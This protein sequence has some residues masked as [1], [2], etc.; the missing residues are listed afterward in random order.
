M[1]AAGLAA[2]ATADPGPDGSLVMIGGNLKENEQILRTIVK[3]AKAADG[4][5][6]SPTIAIITAAAS[7]ARTP[8]QGRNPKK[9]NAQANGLYYSG[10]FEALGADTYA[11]PI[12][13]A[14]DFK[15]DPYVPGNAESRRV[16][17]KVRAADGVFFGGGDQ[18][19]YVRTLMKDC[20]PSDAPD[21]AYEACGD[22]RVL[23]AVRDVLARGGVVAGVSAGTTIQQGPDMVTGGESYQGWQNGAEPG[24][25]ADPAELAYLPAGGFNFFTAGLVDS[26]F[27]TWG[28]QARM[29]R[30]AL[31][32]GHGRVFGVDETTALVVDRGSDTAEVIGLNG[33]SVLD[34]SGAELSGDQDWTVDGVRWTYLVAG[35]KIDLADLDVTEGGPSLVRTGSAPAPI[36]DVWDSIDG[37]GNVYSLRNLA[38]DLAASAATQATGTTYEADPQ[39]TTTVLF[40]GATSAWDGAGAAGI[41]FD[42]LEVR[43]APTP[44]E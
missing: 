6:D 20:T 16:A 10:L 5:D 21:E 8:G 42:G 43:I 22:T 33:V 25:L 36:S 1:G 27:T 34:V 9:N 35:D 32:T 30:L 19:R 28:R 11:V 38:R 18:M 2:P 17:A 23:S 41:G 12:D 24:Y 26:H 3:K 13:V 29:I 44:T 31:H 40:D 4:A 15:N 14:E 39:F 7:P 37:P